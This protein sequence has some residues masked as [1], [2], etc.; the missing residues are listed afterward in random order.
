[1][2]YGKRSIKGAS[3]LGKRGI[4]AEKIGKTVAQLTKNEM[5]FSASV[6]SFMADQLMVP[7]VFSKE[8]SS[9]TFPELTDHVKTNLNIIE[10]LL[11]PVISI[12]K[13]ENYIRAFR[14]ENKLEV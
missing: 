12:E 8:K 4:P 2:R 5:Q 9:Y 13:E 10:Q 7:L 1:M 14:N 3:A 6:D 11:G